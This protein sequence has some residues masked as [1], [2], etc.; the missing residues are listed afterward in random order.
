MPCKHAVAAIW[1]MAS[2]GIETEI[3]ESYCNPC[4]WLITWKEMYRFKINPV[5]G[6]HSWP[7][8]DS[9]TIIVPPV[10]HKQIGRPRKKRRKSAAELAD[11]MEKS[12]KLTRVGK[13]V[14]CTLCKQVGHNKRTC[15]SNKNVG[16]S[17]QGA[18]N[19]GGSQQG[20]Q[21][22]GGSQSTKDGAIG[23][24]ASSTRVR[25][26]PSVLYPS[27]TKMTKTKVANR[28]S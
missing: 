1:D 22:V 3:P 25:V 15:K 12:G 11:A 28:L 27:P 8:S 9:Q 7:K 20:A 24:Q 2:N 4:H 10:Y 18:Q 23:T 21:N 6:P 17:Q 13:S 16:G 19:V 14:T 5:E 26:H